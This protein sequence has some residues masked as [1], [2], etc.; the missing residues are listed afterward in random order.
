MERANFIVRSTGEMPATTDWRVLADHTLLAK[1]FNM[2]LGDNWGRACF[3]RTTPFIMLEY[4]WK[5][6]H[7]YCKLVGQ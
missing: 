6:Q 5:E 4:F 1:P 3:D 7:F 2:V